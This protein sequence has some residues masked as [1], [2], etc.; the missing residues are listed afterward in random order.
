MPTLVRRGAG[1]CCVFRQYE[2]LRFLLL[3]TLRY[4]TLWSMDMATAERKKEYT[5]N[6]AAEM[7]GKVTARIRQICIRH[8]IGRLIEN[9]IRLL[10][11][12][13]IRK[14]G[15]IIEET[16]RGEFSPTNDFPAV[17]H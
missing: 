1:S 16:G 7:F 17:Q 3:S 12:A 14:I 15:K 5:V 8:K 2:H 6:D 11:P 13:D 10:S 4:V 9:R